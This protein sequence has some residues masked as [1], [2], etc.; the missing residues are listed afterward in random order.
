MLLTKLSNYILNMSHQ[1]SCDLKLTKRKNM[2]LRHLTTRKFKSL[3]S[4]VRSN[5]AENNL[6]REAHSCQEVRTLALES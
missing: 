1:T 2:D 3:R 6:S 4:A 5:Y